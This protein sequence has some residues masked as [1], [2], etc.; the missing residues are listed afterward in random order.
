MDRDANAN[1]NADSR[2]FPLLEP[3]SGA[4]LYELESKR[5]EGLKRRGRVMKTGCAEMDDAVLLGGLERGCV[6]GVSAEDVEF[7]LLVGL[8]IAAH[9]LVF[10]DESKNR[11]RV[12][13]VTTLAPAAILPTLR[14]VIRAQVQVR[15]GPTADQRLD[16]VSA[17]VRRCL[18]RISISRVFDVEGLWEVL[19]ELETPPARGNDDDVTSKERGVETAPDMGAAAEEEKEHASRAERQDSPHPETSKEEDQ[20]LKNDAPPPSSPK[21]RRMEVADSE[22]EED[23]TL[24]SSPLSPPPPS[25]P[26]LPPSPLLP[27]IE[28]AVQATTPASTTTPK[29]TSQN[30]Q[31]PSHIPDI[32]LIT[33]FSTLLTNLFT[34]SA[35]NKSRAH[36]S[37]RALSS[38]LRSLARSSAGPLVMLLNSTTSTSTSSLFSPSTATATTASSSRGPHATMKDKPLDPPTLRSVFT[39][40]GGKPAFGATFAQFVDVHLMGLRVP[41]TRTRGDGRWCWVVEVLLDEVGVEVEVKDDDGG[42]DGDGIGNGNKRRTWKSREQRW[43]AV[44]V[45]SKVKIGD[46]VLSG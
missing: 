4:T 22:D 45:R 23:L 31:V 26:N 44:D 38:H 1:A 27:P 20:I 7:G 29:L 14:D 11:Q 18:E 5:R 6:V 41:R 40:R 9:T 35:D 32:I 28:S 30:N 15:L 13:I 10:D 17:E 8:Q 21:A 16:V 3:M 2:A 12:S 33:H 42:G 39:G 19:G 36:D 37:L 34:R 43:G 46:A 24:S 25:P